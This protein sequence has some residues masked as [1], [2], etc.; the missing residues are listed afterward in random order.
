MSFKYVELKYP[1]QFVVNGTSIWA[2]TSIGV[3]IAYTMDNSTWYY[4]KGEADHSLDSE[5]KL[6]EATDEADAQTN[7]WTTGITING[8]LASAIWPYM[9]QCLKV[10]IYFNISCTIY[11]IKNNVFVLADEIQAGTMHLAREL[12]IASTDDNENAVKMTKDGLDVYGNNIHT[13]HL[14]N[15]GT[16]YF[17]SS[18]TGS[19]LLYT[20]SGLMAYD[21]NSVQKVNITNSGTFWFGAASGANSLTFD[22]S[23]LIL[24]GQMI[25]TGGSGIANLSD[26]TLDYIA[27]GTSYSKTTPNQVTGAGRA[28]TALDS[29]NNVITAIDPATPAPTGGGAG[30]YLGSDYLGYYSGS[31]WNCYIANDG[32]FKFYGTT[33][34]SI[35]WNGSTLAI[36]GSLTADDITTGT[37]NASNVS[38]T[39]L[40]ASNI[41]TGTLSASVLST[42]IAYITDTAQIAN[43]IITNAKIGNL[44]VDS[45]KIANLT[46]G[47]GKIT[48]NAI[49]SPLSAVT[50]GE[51]D[52]GLAAGTYTI[53]SITITTT[54]NPILI[55]CACQLE[56]AIWDNAEAP[57]FK[58]WALKLYRDST[59]LLNSGNMGIIS[60]YQ[61]QTFIYVD[62]PAAGTYTYYY[63]LYHEASEY[64]RAKVKNRV[65]SLL[66]TKGK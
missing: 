52:T 56:V 64:G 16:F 13:V 24:N 47:T 25:I 55:W 26:A 18:E 3:Y 29:S 32:K 46:V 30:L 60:T 61:G 38:V 49:T 27:N 6:L 42:A 39:N 66:G 54:G 20:H 51:Y 2:S 53:Q 58:S 62:T 41:T 4:L 45:A 23:T 43:A 57:A 17:R 63:Y 34:H 22:G 35:E 15:D 50:T 33:G 37:L 19:R 11:E 10:R 40:N 12:T 14:D 5:G 44:E 9:R 59:E 7:Y 48:D 31:A 36:R 8:Q 65:I 28:Y 21:D 1:V